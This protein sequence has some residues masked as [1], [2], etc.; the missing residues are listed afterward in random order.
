MIP[1]FVLLI[2]LFASSFA[3]AAD[4]LVI[5]SPHRKTIQREFIP[6]FKS[7]YKKKYG[8]E[9]NIDW[10]D[11]G[12]TSNAVRYLSGK[13]KKNPKTVGIDLFWGGT[14]ANFIDLADQNVFARYTLP[15]ELRKSIPTICAGIPMSDSKNRWHAST[16]SSFG[17]VSNR[18]VMK[19]LR[20]PAPKSWSDLQAKPYHDQ[21]MLADPRKSGTNSTMMYIVLQN[22]G[23][24]EGWK[25]LTAISGNAKRFAHS[26]SDPVNA[27]V[28]GDVASA[29]V[30]DFYGMSQ[31]WEYGSDRV[32]FILPSGQTI[33]DPD[34][35]AIIKNA[36]H[37]KVA[38]RFVD[39]VLSQEAQ[40]LWIL[41]KG[42]PGGPKNSHLARLAIR[43]DVYKG[44]E[45][46][47]VSMNPFEQ[48]SFMKIDLEAAG[49]RRRVINDLIG[50]VL[51]DSH[52]ELKNAWKK[53]HESKDRERA[54]AW[55]AKP[56][57][58]LK[59]VDTIS[60][61][62]EDN[63]FRNQQINKWIKQAQAKFNRINKGE[64]PWKGQL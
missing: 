17:I 21:I 8:K 43:P 36:P 53:V 47:K 41:P 18:P 55:L 20:I 15:Q 32:Q 58:S 56:P 60:K 49:R 11:Q 46:E 54:L 64:T 22:Q 31:V 14:S 23:W 10:L 7:H 57:V 16:I 38:E 29:M 52:K 19:M 33:L 25:L 26:S 42:H 4:S 34:P 37:R 44:L 6:V 61:K 3:M 50:S 45:K 35:V 59:E 9:V 39:F 24:V 28:T 2:S 62:W 13:F 40:K 51:V 5:L 63:I 1:F 48:K 27:V 30:I 12:G